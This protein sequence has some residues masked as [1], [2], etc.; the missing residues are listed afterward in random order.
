MRRILVIRLSALG[1]VAILAPVLRQRAAA[2]PDVVFVVAGPPLLEPLFGDIPNVQYAGLDKRQGTWH[3]FK[4]L[5]N[6]EADA[7]ADLHVVNRVTVALLLLRLHH[8]LRLDFGVRFCALRKGR[9]SR[10]RMLTHRDMTPRRPQWQRYD[11]VF[12]RLG[13]KGAAVE[14][15]LQPKPRAGSQCTVGVAPYAQ[16]SGKV[17]PLER[18]AQLVRMLA[19]TGH[20]VLLF[21]SRAEAATLQPWADGCE[22]V[23]VV[24]GKGSFEQE[25]KAIA[26]LDIMVSMDSANMHF[27]SALGVPVVSIWGATH[28]DFGFYGFGQPR[29]AALCTGLRCQPCSAFGQRKCRFGTYQCLTD[30]TPQMAFERVEDM[31]KSL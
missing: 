14:P 26:G 1:D 28:P 11:D 6:I 17:W 10:R 2:N 5:R 27:A 4:T 3:I 25:L 20:R 9:R 31:L 22:G 16:H 12:A 23:Q 15:C 8:W 24:A 29:S 19:E 21:G 18:T 13:L 30:I 7:V